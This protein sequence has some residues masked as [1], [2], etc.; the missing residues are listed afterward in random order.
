MCVSPGSVNKVEASSEQD[1][2]ELSGLLPVFQ[3]IRNSILL[4]FGAGTL[5]RFV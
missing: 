3:P 4:R 5:T 2:N 1:E